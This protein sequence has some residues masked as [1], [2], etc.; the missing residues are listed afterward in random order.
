[1]R[2]IEILKKYNNARQYVLQNCI[3][4]ISLNAG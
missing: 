1:M 4:E 2:E 3:E